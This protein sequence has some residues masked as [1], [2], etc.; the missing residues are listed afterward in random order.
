MK[1]VVRTDRAPGA[2]GPYSQA[3]RAQGWLWVAGQIALDP[4]TG[5]L[6]PGGIEEQ[7]RQVLRNVKAILEAAGSGLDRVVKVTVYLTDLKGY[8]T[9]N[10][11]YIEFLPSPGPARACVEVCGLPRGALVEV[12]AVAIAG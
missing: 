5:A 7:T 4:A 2:L 9:M 3:V 6:V 10:R 1:E 12:D 8:E 11:A